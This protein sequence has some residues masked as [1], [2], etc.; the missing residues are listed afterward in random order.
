MNDTYS[1]HEIVHCRS[2]GAPMFFARTPKGKMIP[3]DRDPHPDGNIQFTE[4]GVVFLSRE[5]VQAGRLLHST[6]YLSHFAT[7]P[8]SKQH[9]KERVAH[10]CE[11]PGPA[12]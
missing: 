5:A 2:C 4:K 1:N 3:L 9:R 10:D 11:R 12:A 8:N 6:R 7:C